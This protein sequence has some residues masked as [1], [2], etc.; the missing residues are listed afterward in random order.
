MGSASSSL[1]ADAALPEAPQAPAPRRLSL[2][3][4]VPCFNE[5]ATVAQVVEEFRAALPD[6]TVYVYDNA[7]SDRTADRARAAGAVVRRE[8]M[9]GKGNV[10]RRM[11]A[12]IDADVYLLVDGDATY[13]AARAPDL[14]KLLLSGPYDLVNGARVPESAGVYRQGHRVGN[15]L[16]TG[17]IGF[18]FGQR[19]VD[20]LSGYKAFSRRFVKTFPALASGFEIETELTV[21]A[22]DLRMPVAEIPTPYRERIAGSMSKLSTYRDG[23]RI[24]WMIVTLAKEERPLPFFGW[25]SLVL[26]LISLALGIPVVVE[27]FRTGL[28][29]RLPTA[30]LSMGIMVLSFLGLACGLILDTVTRGRREQKRLRY[31]AFP[32]VHGDGAGS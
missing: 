13:D 20:I 28:V 23:L 26:A 6:A 21:H 12:D 3:V 30:V 4:L 1:A 32:S 11:F 16:L 17:L 14:V 7:S 25:I 9:P 2:A 8:E 29:P 31:L 15:R 24:L 19:F 10:V 27:F 22:L 18:V 5:E